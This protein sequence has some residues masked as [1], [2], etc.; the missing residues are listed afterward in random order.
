MM[1]SQTTILNLCLTFKIEQLIKAV[2]ITD[3]F[4]SS[5]KVIIHQRIA[6]SYFYCDR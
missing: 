4:E 6:I 3:M 1:F 5:K 2:T